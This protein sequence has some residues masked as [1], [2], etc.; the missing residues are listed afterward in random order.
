MMEHAQLPPD[1]FVTEVWIDAA[2]VQQVNPIPK[3]APLRVH[4]LQL[5]PGTVQLTRIISPGEYPVGAEHNIAREEQE[6][7]H[8]DRRTES[9][10]QQRAELSDVRHKPVESQGRVG[11][12]QNL[13]NL[14]PTAWLMY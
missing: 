10:K 8:G 9:R 13:L 12:K 4:L 7:K 3:L 6:K 1:Q 5:C 11:R 2:G 14:R